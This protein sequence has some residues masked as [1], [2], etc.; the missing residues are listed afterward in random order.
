MKKISHGAAETWRIALTTLFS[1]MNSSLCNK[2]ITYFTEAG[3]AFIAILCGWSKPIG[4]LTVPRGVFPILQSN[5]IF[6]AG[7]FPATT[8]DFPATTGK[9]PA[10]TGKVPTV[11][12][13]K[14]GLW[15]K[16]EE[17]ASRKGVSKPKVLLKTRGCTLTTAFSYMNSSLYNKYRT[18]FMEAVKVPATIRSCF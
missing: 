5:N 2:S 8:G 11:T 15:G 10:T 17:K 3:K 9:V 16:K 7:D 1:S 13:N 12:A 6:V 18:Y 14:N 4:L